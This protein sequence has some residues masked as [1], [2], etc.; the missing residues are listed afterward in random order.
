MATYTVLT[1][2]TIKNLLQS[3]DLGELLDFQIMDG[4]QANSSVIDN[5]FDLIIGKRYITMPKL[6]L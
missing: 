4:G 1:S 5:M 2:Q 6:A 3:Y